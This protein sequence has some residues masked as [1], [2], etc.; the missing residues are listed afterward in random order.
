S[1]IQ[2]ICGG[3]IRFF[4]EKTGLVLARARRRRGKLSENLIYSW[5]LPVA[6]EACG[7]DLV[8]E[9]LR[10]LANRARERDAV[11]QLLLGA[12]LAQPFVVTRR[13]AL[14]RDEARPGVADVEL[15][16]LLGV[17][18]AARTPTDARHRHRALVG[19]HSHSAASARNRRTAAPI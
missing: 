7:D 4:E 14:A 15:R 8:G 6:L 13:Q 17:V 9:A 10:G 1:I 16:R 18:A 11:W 3:R 12:E 5:P 19:R 2:K